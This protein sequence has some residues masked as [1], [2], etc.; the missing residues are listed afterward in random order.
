MALVN[1]MDALNDLVSGCI[2]VATLCVSV[3]MDVFGII[4]F[5]IA[6]AIKSEGSVLIVD[7]GNVV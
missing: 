3:I 6:A 4:G 5:E 1:R 2:A 7:H